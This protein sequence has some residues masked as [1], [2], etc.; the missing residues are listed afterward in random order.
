MRWNASA[1][2]GPARWRAQA[3]QAPRNRWARTSRFHPCANPMPCGWRGWRGP[4]PCRN[5]RRARF[6]CGRRMP[7][8]QAGKTLFDVGLFDPRAGTAALAA[9]HAQCFPDAWDAAAIA[10]LLATPGTFA[11]AHDD[12]FALAR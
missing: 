7:S 6:I 12:G 10:A 9:L 2:S 4:C 3:R 5:M 8:F 11:Y 1:L